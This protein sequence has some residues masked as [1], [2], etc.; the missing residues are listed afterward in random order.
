MANVLK[1]HKP[2][3]EVATRQSNPFYALQNELD[4]VMNDFYSL[5]AG[6]RYEFGKFEGLKL[7]PS[8]DIIETKD[9]FKVECELPGLNESEV[10]VLVGEKM[11]TIRGE[12]EVS[13][14]DQG[15]NYM[16]REIGYG[17]YERNIALPVDLD[18]EHAVATFKKGML[19]IDIPKKAGA[20][21]NV[22]EL[23][24]EKQ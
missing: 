15:Q 2:V 7:S 10:K 6:Q 1:W 14:K 3:E 17:Y 24:I 8:I 5:F 4:R 12:K 16:L 21:E 13:T 11:L 23:K 18:T 19:W 20:I 22:R 9:H